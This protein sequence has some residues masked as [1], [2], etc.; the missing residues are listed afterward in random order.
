MLPHSE[1]GCFPPRLMWIFYVIF[2]TG[3]LLTKTKSGAK[4]TATPAKG[5]EK[6][7]ANPK[8]KTTP[9]KA[10]PKKARKKSKAGK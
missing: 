10:A 5:A 4:Q 1:K 7:K 8:K 6:K 9:K 3:F 2:S